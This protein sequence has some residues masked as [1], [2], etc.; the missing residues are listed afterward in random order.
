MTTETPAPA[1]A[2]SAPVTPETYRVDTLRPPA[3]P[4]R[5]LFFDDEPEPALVTLEPSSA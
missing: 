4:R 1:P 5:R 3:A 2:T